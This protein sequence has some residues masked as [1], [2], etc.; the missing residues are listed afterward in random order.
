MRNHDHQ[1]Q[2]MV[3]MHVIEESLPIGDMDD[4]L[5]TDTLICQKCIDKM[6]IEPFDEYNLPKEVHFACKQCVL[7]KLQGTIGTVRLIKRKN[8]E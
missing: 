7:K 6:C 2:I 1:K 3:C 5:K 8:H 4:D